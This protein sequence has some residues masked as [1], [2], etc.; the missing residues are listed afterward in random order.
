MNIKKISRLSML[1]AL[2]VVIGIIENYIIV[3]NNIIPGLK[4][5]LANTVIIL[6]L[7]IYGFKDALCVSILRVILVSLLINGL[8][9]VP[10][11]FSLSGAILSIISMALFKKLK[12]FSQIS[13]SVIGSI[14][15]SIG[16]ILVG[17]LIINKSIIYYLP[18]LLIFSIIT[19]IITGIISKKILQN[20]STLLNNVA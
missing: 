8:F 13:V 10:F 5:G 15:H 11:Y 12:I 2:S 19:G 17:I 20:M 4:L 6:V 16:Q 18:Y 1:T 3:L 14:A 7:Y 9:T